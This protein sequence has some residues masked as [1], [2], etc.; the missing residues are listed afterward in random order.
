MKKRCA[1]DLIV[2]LLL[3]ANLPMPPAYS[4]SERDRER[5]TTDGEG[6]AEIRG[7]DLSRA[8]GE[9]LE[10]ALQK[11]F[12]NALVEILPLDL[13]LTGRQDILDQ[14][15]TRLKRYLLQ[16]RVLSEFPALQVFFVNV[17]ATFSVPLIGED[18]ASLGIAWTEEA[19]GEPVE[20][21]VR[22]KG[23]TSVRLYQ[24]LIQLF[25]KMANVKVATPYE[26]FGTSVVIR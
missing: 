21:F 2:A 19:T 3:L 12:E 1:V 10:D 6:E 13:S 14:L 11:A 15:A 16:Y 18:L 8:R 17:E 23:V 22:V 5:I 25:R 20:L 4:M 7:Q 26:L 24:E 9:A